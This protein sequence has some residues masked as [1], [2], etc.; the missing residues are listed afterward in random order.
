MVMGERK[1]TTDG[2]SKPVKYYFFLPD[3]SGEGAQRTELPRYTSIVFDEN[4]V[5]VHSQIEPDTV[6]TRYMSARLD[7]AKLLS[8]L[9][10]PE[11]ADEFLDAIDSMEALTEAEGSQGL[12]ASEGLLRIL[13]V[14]HANFANL[15]RLKNLKQTK[16]EDLEKALGHYDSAIKIYEG[17]QF[18][19]GDRIIEEG[20]AVAWLDKA[21]ALAILQKEAEAHDLF[22]KS[23]A[24]LERLVGSGSLE[25]RD[26]LA[27]AYVNSAVAANMYDRRTLAA[28][29]FDKAIALY[30]RLAAEATGDDVAADWAWAV[31]VRERIRGADQ[32]RDGSAA[33]Q[34]L[35]GEADRTGRSALGK[36]VDWL[37][38][39]H[40]E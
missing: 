35:Q 17:L 37:R 7:K 36:L 20:L 16:R 2:P 26:K 23:I 4:E 10:K 25:V 27:K 15:I 13:A 3:P 40:K 32:G 12:E 8:E 34:I 11:A 28:H 14:A 31:A 29:R 33:I 30:Q 21:S 18:A 6:L 5:K 22:E 24:V 9:G 19:N 39:E 1:P 38:N